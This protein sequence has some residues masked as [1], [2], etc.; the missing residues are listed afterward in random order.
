M[1]CLLQQAAVVGLPLLFDLVVA[2][3]LQYY[4]F[5]GLQPWVLQQESVAVVVEVPQ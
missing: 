5:V 1:Y 4:Q 3:V 2:D